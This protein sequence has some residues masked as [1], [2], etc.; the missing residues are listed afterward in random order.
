MIMTLKEPFEPHA[1]RRQIL[2]ILENGRV[3]FSRHAEEE[4][5]KDGILRAD[6][7]G[8]LRGG[9]VQPGEHRRGSWR[10]EVRTQK[11]SVVVVFRT[12]DLLVVVTAWRTKQ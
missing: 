7:L 1:A 11:L 12:A 5:R 10:H 9:F 8:V 6:V 3:R 4:M 2:W